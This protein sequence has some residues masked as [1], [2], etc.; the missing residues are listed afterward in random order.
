MC[1]LFSVAGSGRP[2]ATQQARVSCYSGKSG[3]HL[4]Q[5]PVSSDELLE[6]SKG[7]VGLSQDMS[8]SEILFMLV[9]VPN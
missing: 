5:G 1:E 8:G 4:S 9:L 2:F 3:V 7:S 6:S